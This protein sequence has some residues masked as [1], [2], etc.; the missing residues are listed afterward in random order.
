[1]TRDLARNLAEG[2]RAAGVGRIF[3]VPGGGANL[4]MIGAAAELGIPFTLTHGETA[5][6]IMAGTYGR[7]TQSPGVALTTRGPGVT[8]AANGLAQANLDRFPLLLISD[9]VGV[10][11]GARSAHQ[12]LDQVGVS[13]PLT[14]WA[15]TLGT[16]DPTGVV[17]AAARHTLTP[18]AGAVSLS[19]DP[20]IPG[21]AGPRPE[22]TG[23]ADTDAMERACTVA[24]GADHPVILVGLDAVTSAPSVR[25]AL[26]EVGCPILVTYEAKGTIPESWPTYAGLFT[27]AQMERPL[28]Q[29]ADLI[30]GIGLDPVEPMSTP[31]SYPAPVILLARHAMETA[32]FGRPLALVG[33]YTHGL[34]LLLDAV[35][36]T[37]EPDIGQRTR[38]ADLDRLAVATDGLDP[39]DV[40]RVTRDER[41]DALLTVDAGAHMLAAMPLWET[42]E[43]GSV[44]ISNGLATMGFSLAAAIGTALAHRDRPVVC[45][46]GDGGLGM[47]LAELETVARL[48]LDITVVVF[49]D[50]ALSLIELKQGGAQGGHTAVRYGPSDL[51]MVARG[52]GVP[53]TVVEDVGDLRRTLVATRGAG[54]PHLIDARIDPSA[55][56]HVL[57]TIRG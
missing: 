47:V 55:Y 45:F 36:P 48:D 13:T 51:A 50:A 30:I 46:T 39:L 6:C 11:D 14:K 52:M 26:A 5:A 42:D 41:P 34:P 18:P 17:A 9:A 21:D 31:W 12:R 53:G 38:R 35:H 25:S 3:G 7:I 27:G 28:L 44:Q 54:G 32:Y 10:V 40:V 49:N 16:A 24:A 33:S 43:A 1:M 15:G 37:W 57:A 20:D 2:L 29:Q 22:P 19:F 23:G 8:S 56:P 4:D